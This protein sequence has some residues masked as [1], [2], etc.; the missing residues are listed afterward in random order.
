MGRFFPDREMEPGVCF[1]SDTV[2][3][4]RSRRAWGSNRDQVSS[5]GLHFWY[6]I[7]REINN[8]KTPSLAKQIGHV[9]TLIKILNV[10]FLNPLCR[11]SIQFGNETNVIDSRMSRSIPRH[12]IFAIATSPAFPRRGQRSGVDT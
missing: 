2:R 1:S 5:F 8:K 10:L 12:A 6:C 7:R 4:V 3:T 9:F 11:Y